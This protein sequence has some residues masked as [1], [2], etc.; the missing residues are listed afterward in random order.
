MKTRS[1]L[2]SCL[3][4]AAT[5]S[6]G[7]PGCGQRPAAPSDTSSTAPP[8]APAAP[9]AVSTA[10]VGQPPSEPQPASTAAGYERLVGR[11]LRPDG[12]YILEVR[13]ISPEGTVDAAYLNPR[14]IRVAR[15]EASRMGDGMTLFVE[16]RDVN[17]P[18]SAYRLIYDRGRDVLTGT[19]FQALQGQTFDVEFVRR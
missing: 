1:T 18:G 13:S 9:P 2:A 5:L 8:L 4:V 15:A 19:Y 3:A 11:W 14:P 12:G 6:W 16:L 7:L 10:A 17:Y